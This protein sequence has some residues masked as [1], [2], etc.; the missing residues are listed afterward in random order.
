VKA[1]NA[2]YKEV[3]ELLEDMA[4]SNNLDVQARTKALGLGKNKII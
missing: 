3:V 1:V 2:S 4:L